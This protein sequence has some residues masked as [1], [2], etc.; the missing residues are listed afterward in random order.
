MAALCAWKTVPLLIRP[1][2]EEDET[3]IR[4]NCLMKVIWLMTSKVLVKAK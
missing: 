4:S 1:L 3:A 2:P